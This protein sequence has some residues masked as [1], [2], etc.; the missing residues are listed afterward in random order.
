[1]YRLWCTSHRHVAP[2]GSLADIRSCKHKERAYGGHTLLQSVWQRYTVSR[3]SPTKTATCLAER[4]P[5]ETEKQDMA[6]WEGVCIRA[7]DGLLLST[8]AAALLRGECFNLG[9]AV[10]ARG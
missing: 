10:H 4:H 5:V 2:L 1:M 3:F 7:T 9:S 6:C 8:C